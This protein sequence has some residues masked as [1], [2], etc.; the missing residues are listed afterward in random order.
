MAEFPDACLRGLRS[1]DF[2]LS[3]TQS[4]SAVIFEPN[5]KISANRQDRACETSINW[6]DDEQALHLTL[7]N[8]QIAA[9]GAARLKRDVID[10]I[11][12]L[13][14]L[15]PYVATQGRCVFYERAPL[16]DNQYHGN[17]LFSSQI[18][19]P[20]VRMISG[21]LAMHSEYVTR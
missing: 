6:E 7:R 5:Y 10:T 3:D 16:P 12:T 1:K 20:V 9:Y 18:P 8:H 14:N 11:N 21:Y 17:V 2:V 4:L 13:P 19:K 15:K